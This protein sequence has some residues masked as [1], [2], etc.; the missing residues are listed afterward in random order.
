MDPTEPPYR[1][2]EILKEVSTYIKKTGYNP[3]TV[4]FVPI[5]DWKGDNMLEQVLTR[6]GSR[7]G[8]SPVQ[9][10]MTVEPHC[11]KLWIAFCHLLV[12]LTSPCVC[13]SRRLQ[14][15]RYWY[16]PCGLSG[17][18][19]SPGM[20]VTFVPVD[21][22]TEVKSVGIYHEALSEALPGDDVGF[23]AKNVSVQDVGRGNVAGDS[24]SDPPMGAAGFTAQFAE[25]KEKIDRGSGKKL[26]DGSTFL[27][28]GDASMVGMVPGKPVYRRLLW[29]ASKQWTRRQL[30]LARS[31]GLP[32]KLRKLNEHYAHTCLGQ[33]RKNGV[34]TICARW[35]FKYNN[36]RPVDDNNAL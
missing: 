32:R 14:N 28:S 15:W 1:Y 3:H 21:A 4:A 18:W 7:D 27:K 36:K 5:S 24:R 30:E 23:N 31:P 9:M 33:W 10:A 8:K 17:D 19:C 22:T 13:P 29:V 2:E 26:E 20:V 11:L 35:P 6:L 16:C 12:Q 25:L 34:T